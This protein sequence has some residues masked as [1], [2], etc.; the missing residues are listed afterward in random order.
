MSQIYIT[1]QSYSYVKSFHCE[2]ICMLIHVHNSI[3][4]ELWSSRAIFILFMF[5]Y[6]L[7][8]SLLFIHEYLF[9][10]VIFIVNVMRDFFYGIL[11]IL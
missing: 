10:Y 9:I 11:P 1:L 4:S 7:F 6:Y 5:V 2:I 3:V 8:N